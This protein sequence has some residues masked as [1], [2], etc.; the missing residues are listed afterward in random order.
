MMNNIKIK[1]TIIRVNGNE[2]VYYQIS[3]N[4]KKF[5]TAAE[6]LKE[7]FNDQGE[8]YEKIFQV[9]RETAMLAGWHAYDRDFDQ[10][11]GGWKEFLKSKGKIKKEVIEKEYDLKEFVHDY[12]GF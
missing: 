3:D 4:D 8:L 9:D 7:I 11:C 12:I 6:V 10:K 2:K 5:E 1:K